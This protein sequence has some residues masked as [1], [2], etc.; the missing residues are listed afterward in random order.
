LANNPTEAVKAAQSWLLRSGI[1]RIDPALGVPGG[2][3]AWFD[4][5]KGAHAFLYSE[6][7]GYALTTFVH[8]YRSTGLE[9]Y[10]DRANIAADWLVKEAMNPSGAVKCRQDSSG[11][12]GDL[13]A[14][15]AGMCLNGLVNLYRCTAEPRWLAAAQTIGD[16]LTGSLFREDGGFY[17]KFNADTGLPYDSGEKWSAIS[18]SFLVKLA[19]GLLN[20]SDATRSAPYVEAVSRLC[21]WGLKLQESDG[22]FNTAPTSGETFVHPHCYTAEGLLVAG[23]VLG[24]QEWVEAAAN[25][26]SWV[27]AAQLSDGAF[28]A[29]YVNGQFMTTTSP[30]VTSQVLRLWLLLP[31]ELRANSSLNPGAV[32]DSV[33]RAQCTDESLQV[34]GGFPAGPGWFYGE[35]Q[36]RSGDHVNS[37]V[38]MFS[39]QALSLSLTDGKDFDPFLI[40]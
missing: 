33:I 6:I 14:F 19:I 8:L 16:W 11:W 23:L 9:V 36:D 2:V 30:D 4:R 24:R 28:P 17:S 32:V 3:H 27:S 13:Y 39:L 25:A 37:W 22:R 12:R 26:V 31:T 21:E 5:P 7:T 1:Q 40:V 10:L 18:G 15:D 38:T 29:H 20:L 34:S 35:P